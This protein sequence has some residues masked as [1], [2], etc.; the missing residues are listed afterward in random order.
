MN[1]A[2]SLRKPTLRNIAVSACLLCVLAI[3]QA[4]HGVGT[5]ANSVVNNTARVDYTISGVP[6]FAIDSVSF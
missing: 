3:S 6:G 5:A 1:A 4:A 2:H